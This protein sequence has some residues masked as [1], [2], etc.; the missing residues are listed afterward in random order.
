MQKSIIYF[1]CLFFII[2][3]FG[4]CQNG[5]NIPPNKVQENKNLNSNIELIEFVKPFNNS[6]YKL[7]ESITFQMRKASDTITIDSVKFS[8]EGQNIVTLLG[9][10]TEINWNSK[11]S[12]LGHL[13]VEATAFASGGRKQEI[14]M[15]ILLLSDIKPVLY[16]YKIIRV[17]P[18]SRDSYTQGLIYENGYFYESAGEYGTSALKKVKLET[19]ESVMFVS[20]DPSI[21][22]EGIAI[23]KDKIYQI[24]YKEHAGFVYDKATFKLIRKFSFDFAEG[25]GLEF[26]GKN[27]LMTD[28]GYTVYFME[29]EYFTQV[30]K[31]E[32]TSDEGTID[33]INELEL[34][35]GKL[36]ANVYT[37]DY[38]LIIDPKNGKVLG[39]IDF[40][41]ILPKKDYDENT[42]VLNGIAWNPANGHLFIT[43]KYW[44]KLFEVEI[45]KK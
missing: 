20:L 36:Y 37:Q 14:S 28:G 9:Q 33:S 30:G 45:L 15:V 1:P 7:G 24:T 10:E 3:I 32:V 43:G 29:P 8:I 13:S 6:T 44:P 17:Y 31:I 40:K 42:N 25:W 11:N 35:N 41:G 2:L 22:A 34:I 21:F 26:D 5:K 27:F 23:D 16:A 18:H 12:K 4:S 38:V 39:K 19:G